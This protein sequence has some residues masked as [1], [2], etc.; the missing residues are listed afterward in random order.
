MHSGFHPTRGI[1]S[2]ALLTPEMESLL[3]LDQIPVLA[4]PSASSGFA[5]PVPGSAADVASRGGNPLATSP[6]LVWSTANPQQKQAFLQAM[7]QLPWQDR[8][9]IWTEFQTA[10][11]LSNLS[12]SLMGG[13]LAIVF[14]LLVTGKSK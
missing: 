4:P 1:G 14:V 6:N 8:Y 13:T 12:F 9:T 7:S 10:T 5:P 2:T 11:N 3:Q